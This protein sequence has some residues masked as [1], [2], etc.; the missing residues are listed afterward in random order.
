MTRFALIPAALLATSLPAA[1]D[2]PD[3]V[4]VL[5]ASKHIEARSDFNE[6]NPG[7][8]LTWQPER[9]GASLALYR[10]SYDRTSVAGAVS[11]AVWKGEL[12]GFDSQLDVFAGAAWYPEDGRRFAVY[13]GD[14]IVSAGVSFPFPK[15]GPPAR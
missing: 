6:I 3:R 15:G 4:G 11:F 9:L 14:F 10:N 12:G 7:V 2:G 13:V 5:L 8:I 1:A